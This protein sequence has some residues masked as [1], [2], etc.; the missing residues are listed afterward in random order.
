L[1]LK[2]IV[3]TL[4]SINH[5][6][7]LSELDFMKHFLEIIAGV[8][9]EILDR[10]ECK[11]ERRVY[12]AIGLNI[13]VT[14]AFATASASYAMYSIFKS[15]E[16]ALS[17]GVGWGIT[18]GILDRFLIMTTQKKSSFS[19]EFILVGAGRI[20]M[21]TLIAVVISKPL[22]MAIFNKEIYARISAANLMAEVQMKSTVAALP[23]S[24]EIDRLRQENTD[25]KAEDVQ[26]NE[27]H[28][29][30]FDAMIGEADGTSGS[31]KAGKGPLFAEKS[32]EL[33]RQKEVLDTITAQHQEKIA[34]NDRQIVILDTAKAT[35]V[36]QERTARLSAD[37]ILAQMETLEKMA[38]DSDTVAWSS[39]LI[40]AIF[41]AIDVMPILGKLVMNRTKY[42]SILL[43]QTN[44]VIQRQDALTINLKHEIEQEMVRY[45]TV[46][47]KIG[48]L[49]TQAIIEAA[50]AAQGSRFW[51][52]SVA[53][54]AHDL[55][56][57]TSDELIAAIG[58]V[59][60]PK[61]TFAKAAR[62][63]MEKEVPDLSQRYARNRIY[64][65]RVKNAV[66]DT[67]AELERAVNGF[68]NRPDD[69]DEEGN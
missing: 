21:A 47:S 44:A 38:A 7:L 69:D 18:I 58:A 65:N 57:R 5:Y 40:S 20:A 66:D 25:L 46:Q 36:A 59:R 3:I 23:E 35:K 8:D 26:L 6:H 51:L 29:K 34:A 62:K 67:A 31:T 68:V 61:S 2:N 24:V 49:T 43:H 39:R 48:E 28:Q 15:P 10:P 33:A 4:A 50:T 17:L 37:S 64:R 16:I 9:S 19:V 30:A 54:A 14:T 32:V 13:L 42:D 41:V 1:T 45:N 53:R 60:L 63:A 27:K 22:E 52:R 55:A 11:G 56:K 12:R